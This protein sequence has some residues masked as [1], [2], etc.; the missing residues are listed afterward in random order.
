MA[1]YYQTSAGNTCCEVCR[2]AY[3]EIRVTCREVAIVEQSSPGARVRLEE[4][5][6]RWLRT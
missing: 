3:A 6:G 5:G 2:R 4:V 1:H